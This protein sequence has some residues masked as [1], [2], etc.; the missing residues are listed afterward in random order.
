MP[1][2]M[3]ANHLATN[4]LFVQ[5]LSVAGREIAVRQRTRMPS[6]AVLSCLPTVFRIEPQGRRLLELYPNASS[7]PSK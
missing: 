7:H 3:A 2:T 6:P 4:R 5:A 1:Q